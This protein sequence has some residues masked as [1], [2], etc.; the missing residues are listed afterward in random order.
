MKPALRLVLTFAVAAWVWRLQP[1]TWWFISAAAGGVAIG[2][3][4]YLDYDVAGVPAVDLALPVLVAVCVYVISVWTH[5]RPAWDQYFL[6][7]DQS[8]GLTWGLGRFYTSHLWLTVMGQLAY[9]GAPF[10]IAVLYLLLPRAERATFWWAIVGLTLACFVT[11]R[12]F[13]AAGPRYVF[14]TWPWV[15]PYVTPHVVMTRAALN[16]MPSGHFSWSL[17]TFLFAWRCC[18]WPVRLLYATFCALT[19]VATLGTGEHYWIDLIAALPFTVAVYAAAH[20]P[21]KRWY[22]AL[23][24]ALASTADPIA[25]ETGQ[26]GGAP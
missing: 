9:G 8:M 25:R 15:E 18:R 3:A 23:R 10:W 22:G 21:W 5:E 24:R 2:L 7:I 20:R 13:P 1:G 12:L 14:A 6:V 17:L 16:C 26:A 11:Y 4:R 19:F